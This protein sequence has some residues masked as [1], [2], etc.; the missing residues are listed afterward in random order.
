MD[1][2]WYLL[3]LPLLLLIALGSIPV[4]RL[5]VHLT[6]AGNATAFAEIVA[7]SGG[8]AKVQHGLYLD[9]VFI[10]VFA[11]TVPPVLYSA[12]GWWQLAIA[13]VA[14]DIAEDALCLALLHVPAA[15]F[16]F[17]ALWMLAALKLVA[18]WGSFGNA[19]WRLVTSA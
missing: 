5:Q 2:R 6:M 7:R 9:F 11:S 19:A 18:Y 3:A 14:L 16:W 10:A 13:A 15:G 4:I 8:A 17:T 1:R 12:H